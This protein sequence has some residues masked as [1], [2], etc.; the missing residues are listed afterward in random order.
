MKNPPIGVKVVMAAVCI[1][2]DIKPDRI[3]DPEK[4]GQKVN[5]LTSLVM[6]HQEYWLA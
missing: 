3:N 1:M 5:T 4:P 2:K 6:L